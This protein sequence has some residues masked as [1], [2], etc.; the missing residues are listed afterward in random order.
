MNKAPAKQQATVAYIVVCWNNQDLIDECI[1]SIQAQ[2]YEHKK[3]FL[4]DNASSDDTVN[5]V[6]KQYKDVEVLPQPANY[7]FAKGNNIGITQALADHSVG[8]IALVNTDATL[9]KDWTSTLVGFAD[10]RPKAAT[11]QTITLDYYDHETIDSTHIYISRNGQGTQGSY[12]RATGRE[13]DVLPLKT[14]GCNAAAMLITRKFIEAQPFKNF[15]DEGMFMYLEDVDVAARATIMG[16]DNYVVPGSRA[17]HMGSA[18]SGKN[19][20]FSLYMTYRNNSRL[21]LVNLPF[22]MFIKMIPS[23]LRG[24]RATIKQLKIMGKPDAAQKV[25]RGRLQGIIKLPLAIP[26]AIRMSLTRKISSH[27]LWKL[28]DKGF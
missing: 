1:Q 26:R 20:G 15:F 11:L 12:R 10:A 18:S 24:D 4:V 19:P 27:D 23:V 3:I 5:Y 22:F 14:F 9:K 21:L 7:G 6:R 25:F 28:M 17:Y 2:D 16:W 8:Y 13:L